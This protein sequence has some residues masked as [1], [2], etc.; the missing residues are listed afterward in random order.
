M[1]IFYETAVQFEKYPLFI[2]KFKI[3]LSCKIALSDLL[4]VELF[5][6]NNTLLYVTDRQ[7]HR[8]PFCAISFYFSL[9]K[10]LK[11]GLATVQ[12]R[13]LLFRGRLNFFDLG[14]I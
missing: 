4:S 13:F 6:K 11:G 2:C 14:Q 9:F 7:Y 8:K 5:G 3:T 1:I 10:K 12:I